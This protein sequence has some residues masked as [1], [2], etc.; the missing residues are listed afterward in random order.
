MTAVSALVAA[1]LSVLAGLHIFWAV[2]GSWGSAVAIPER[3]GVPIFRPSRSATL[4]VAV[5]LAA[6]AACAL[7]RGGVVAAQ[8]G[9]LAA[10]IGCW[11]LTVLFGARAVGDGRYVGFFKRVRTTAFGPALS[12]TF[13][14][15]T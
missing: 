15:S 7:V 1:L 13:P 10:Q 4:L 8:G 9:E 12:A 5:G 2:G 3:D 14:L 11:V 6:A